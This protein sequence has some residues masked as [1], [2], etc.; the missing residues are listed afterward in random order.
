MS[1]LGLDT[2]F[3]VV[4]AANYTLCSRSRHFE[5]G[6]ER[7]TISHPLQEV[8]HDSISIL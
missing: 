8:A 4:T 7:Q 1:S 2:S 5:Y 3:I 6:P